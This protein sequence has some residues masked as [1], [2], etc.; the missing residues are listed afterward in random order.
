MSA[1]HAE[2]THEEVVNVHL[3]EVLGESLGKEN[4]V[5]PERQAPGRHKRFDVK[6]EYRGVEFIIEASYDRADAI[7]DAKR[8]VEEGLIETVSIALY[9]GSVAS[10][11][12]SADEIREA[13][14]G[15]DLEVKLFSQ[16][17]DISSSIVK[18]ISGKTMEAE[19]I[20]RDWVTTRVRDFGQLLDSTIEFLV[21]EDV[22]ARLTADIEARTDI[23]IPH[24]ND[25]LN[26]LPGMKKKLPRELYLELF[27]SSGQGEDAVVPDVPDDVVLAHAYISL[28]M[29][30]ILYES[31]GPK[32]GLASLQKLMSTRRGHPLLG[33]KEGFT[34]ILKVN[35]EPVFDIAVALVDSMFP[36]QVNMTVMEDFRD[37][38]ETAQSVVVNRAVLRSD[39]IG[40]IFHKVTGDIATRKGY[41]TFYTKA[42]IA[43]FLAS[44]AFDSP[45]TSWNMDWGDVEAVSKGFRVCD[46]ACGS[47]TLL[48]ASY[49]AI[50][51]LYRRTRF[52]KGE[53]TDLGD[54]HRLL[55]QESIWGFDA[56]EHAAQTASVVL[57]LHEP[58]I[59]LRKMRVYHVAVDR[60]GSLGS[61]N[62][63]WADRQLVPIQRRGVEEIAKEEVAISPFNLIIMNPPFARATAPGVTD[64][65]PRIFDFVS[66]ATAFARLWQSYTRLLR[67]IE[68]KWTSND[69]VERYYKEYVGEDRPFLQRNVDPLNAGATLPFFFLA[70]QYLRANGRLALVL[71][72]TTMESSSYFLL[73]TALLSNYDVNFIVLSSEDGNPNFS[74]STNFSEALVVARKI[75]KN[76]REDLEDAVTHIINFRRQ[77]KDV[78]SGV[79]A[80][81]EILRNLP[82]PGKREFVNTPY[83]EAEISSVRREVLEDFVWNLSPILG[84][85][86]WLE[87]IIAQ[88]T[89]G[90]LFGV[91]LKPRRVGD[92]KQLRVTNPRQFRGDQFGSM[93]RQT[94]SGELRLLAKTGKEIV[95]RLE[96]DPSKTE[97][98]AP[99]SKAASKSY[100]EKGGRLLIPEAIR[101]NTTPL[102][103]TWAPQPIISSRAHM[104]SATPELEKAL[105][106]WIN[107]SFAIT[108]LRT[109]FTTVQEEFGHI[110]GWHI[111]ILRTPDMTDSAL[112]KALGMIF[113]RYRKIEW[114]PLPEQLDAARK[115]GGP[116][117]DYDMDVLKSIAVSGGPRRLDEKQAK[118]GLEALYS[119]LSGF[120]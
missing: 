87:D 59:P 75:Q 29:A 32:H 13:L 28:L 93:F 106:T 31:V 96:L 108:W 80:A 114:P 53:A 20:T 73:R 25:A 47:G 14:E 21:K 39:F 8:R 83:A 115:G 62:Y 77:P 116:R 17:S 44:L 102:I 91:H 7:A 69:S 55:L 58:G 35:Y 100:V 103:A 120:L 89:K 30:A 33:M 104:L 90:R 34:A 78:L 15:A 109:L 40:R 50:Q 117:V 42:P 86:P 45:E 74:Y 79:L 27:S 81:R 94:D 56:L 12:H 99:R 10:G 98:I 22:L 43:Y 112:V 97:P 101:F 24:V 64:S 119:E 2:P 107:S 66:S 16:G 18:Y 1:R 72:R 85:P 49:Q 111:R 61:L 67:D 11:L 9:Y 5:T 113:D 68:T 92:L 84:L 105:C 51:G 71:P 82:E 118:V 70:N 37:L 48:S 65:R 88:L 6:I 41:A 63:W 23:F 95:T 54:F 3:A 76:P 46:L 36:L 52:E 4:V 38:I 60:S 26:A 110:Y 19:E 57:N